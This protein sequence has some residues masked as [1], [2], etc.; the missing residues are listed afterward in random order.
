[1]LFYNI[2]RR[3]NMINT[4]LSIFSSE[5]QL[6]MHHQYRQ[7]STWVQAC[8]QTGRQACRYTGRHAGRQVGRQINRQVHRQLYM[9]VGRQV[10]G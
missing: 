5:L 1:M 9:Y 6:D 8:M 3:I 4:A 10:C 2:R 7:S